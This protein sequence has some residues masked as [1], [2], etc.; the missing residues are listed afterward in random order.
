MS[1]YD[2]VFDSDNIVY[3]KLSENLIGDYLKM[4]NDPNVAKMISK[5]N[6]IYTYEQELEWVKKKLAENAC[7]F[8]MIEKITGEYIGNI[9]IMHQNN[10]IGEIGIFITA[11]KQDKHYGTESMKRIIE[12]GY[13]ELKL[14][15]FELNVYSTNPRAIH[16]Y[17]KVGFVNIGVGKTEDDIHMMLKK[18]VKIGSEKEWIS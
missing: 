11:N 16:C 8:S 6:R 14:D 15:G 4:V 13:N 2:I 12:Y 10:N 3:V 9:E 18:E 17:E 7:I 1:E 5:K